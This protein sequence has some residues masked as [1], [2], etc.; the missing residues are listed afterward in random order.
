MAPKTITPIMVAAAMDGW[1]VFREVFAGFARLP[2][3]V[4]KAGEPAYSEVVSFQKRCS[5]SF[6]SFWGLIE[7]AA[8]LVSVF[9][10]GS[11][12]SARA[13]LTFNMRRGVRCPA[14]CGWISDGG[15]R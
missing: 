2:V 11:V 9:L 12:S 3:F 14:S 10:S 13:P 6:V 7:M 8:S 15:G 4:S 1:P 5:T